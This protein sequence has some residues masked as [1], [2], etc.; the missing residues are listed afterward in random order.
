[1][2]IYPNLLILAL[3]PLN[4]LLLNDSRTHF[5]IFKIK[6]ETEITSL[7]SLKKHAPNF[8]QKSVCGWL[9]FISRQYDM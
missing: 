8:G 1:M 4:F 9:D 2:I 7:Y 5:S 3:F 6:P